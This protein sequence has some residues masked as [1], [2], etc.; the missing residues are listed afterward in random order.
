METKAAEQKQLLE[1]YEEKSYLYGREAQDLKSHA[2][3]LVRKYHETTEEN[4]KE[5]AAHRL[6]TVE[7][8]QHESTCRD[9][10]MAGTADQG[11]N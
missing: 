4:I 10:K 6:M 9:G 11:S 5:A 3:A 2:A 7:Q 8:A 1:H